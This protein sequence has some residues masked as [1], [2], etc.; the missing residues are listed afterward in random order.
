MDVEIVAR[1]PHE[2]QQA[3]LDRLQQFMAN[4]Q[5]QIERVQRAIAE[6]ERV[7]AYIQDIG[8]GATVQ[9]ESGA[10]VQF[11]QGAGASYTMRQR[12]RR[13]RQRNTRGRRR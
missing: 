11:N 2:D 4:L 8:P 3:Y 6:R 10:N 5:V 7:G 12:R 1:L 9:D 13:R